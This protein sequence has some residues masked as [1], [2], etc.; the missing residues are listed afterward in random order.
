MKCPQIFGPVPG[1]LAL[2]LATTAAVPAQ[3]TVP[4]SSA[5]AGMAMSDD[6]LPRLI[7]H[8]FSEEQSKAVSDCLAEAQSQ[9]FPAT[10]LALRLE[11][12]LAKNIDPARIVASLQARLGTLVQARA[13]AQAARYA[14]EPGSPGDDLLVAVALA[15][16]SGV[17]ADNLAEVLRRGNGQATL[18]IA[19]IVE[20]GESLQL[21]GIDSETTRN[22]MNDCMDRD[23]RRMEVLRAVRYA[24]QQHRDGVGGADIRRSLWSGQVAI[25]GAGG[26]HGGGAN[27]RL[28]A[29]GDGPHGP[30]YGGGRAHRSSAQP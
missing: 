29:G 24:I 23:L 20:A 13:M 10:A 22:L 27:D 17:A 8:G 16:E 26:W 18:R 12:G 19:S 3:T 30:G 11:E 1:L 7:Q 4:S 15:L 2:W 9:D 6:Y 5:A 25:E 28:N 21:A 14:L